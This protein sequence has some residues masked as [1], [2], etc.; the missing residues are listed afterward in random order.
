MFGTMQDLLEKAENWLNKGNTYGML[1]IEIAR[2]HIQDV[3]DLMEKGYDVKDDIEK[4]IRKYKSV[5]NVPYKGKTNEQK[6]QATT[7][8]V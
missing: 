6:T 4:L 2:D 8:I 1:E 3:I 7:K 5:K